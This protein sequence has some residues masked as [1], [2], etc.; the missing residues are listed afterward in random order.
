[1]C[2]LRGQSLESRLA[3]QRSVRRTREM[4]VRFLAGAVSLILAGVSA[5]QAPGP[6]SPPR[7][8]TI[9]MFVG[10]NFGPGWW[11][12][13]IDS[14][15]RM[16]A[17]LVDGL[18]GTDPRRTLSAQ[19]REKLLELLKDL[20]RTKERY[21][22]LGP[23][24]VDVTITF[25]LTVGSGREA[26]RYVLNDS[27]VDYAGHPEIRPTLKVMHFLHSL[28]ESKR[29]HLPPPVNGMVPK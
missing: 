8:P 16:K 12:M 22:F 1:M 27:F 19:E 24:Y 6:E 14:R 7:S 9:S 3:A 20:P 18:D 2:P 17:T 15:S 5:G 28:T 21:A 13:N 10:G 11:S 26:R 4:S 23:D 25:D 29:V